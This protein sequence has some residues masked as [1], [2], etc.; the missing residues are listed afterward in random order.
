MQAA[1]AVGRGRGADGSAHTSTSSEVGRW[2]DVSLCHSV[3]TDSQLFGAFMSAAAGVACARGRL[4]AMLSAHVLVAA[5]PLLGPWRWYCSAHTSVW[6]HGRR[7]R[8]ARRRHACVQGWV[9]CI[10]ELDALYVRSDRVAAECAHHLLG[11]Y[12]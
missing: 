2:P 1:G 4:G 7:Q 5:P 12:V 10:I 6:C 11:V 9:L 3:V 8:P